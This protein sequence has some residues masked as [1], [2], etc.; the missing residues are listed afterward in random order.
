MTSLFPN[1]DQVSLDG[2]NTPDEPVTDAAGQTVT[3][4]DDDAPLSPSDEAHAKHAAAVALGNP[5]VAPPPVEAQPPKRNRRKDAGT[6][7]KPRGAGVG[8]AIPA[9][10]T[11][12][13]EVGADPIIGHTETIST[14]NATAIID[15]KAGQ[16]FYVEGE[17]APKSDTHV[18]INLNPIDGKLTAEAFNEAVLDATRRS[19]GTVI[20]LGDM[21]ELG[22]ND[23]DFTAKAKARLKVYGKFAARAR[24]AAQLWPKEPVRY[25]DAVSKIF[26][27]LAMGE[28]RVDAL[29]FDKDAVAELVIGLLPKSTVEVIERSGITAL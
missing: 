16:A 23:I 21:R 5:S 9:T 28:S 17:A 11:P 14:A 20:N 13:V 7:R 15:H 8:D 26:V 18:N 29:Q 22:S 6:P 2:E 25:F 27:D 10:L 19:P 12:V 1:D 4:D 3:E 24:T